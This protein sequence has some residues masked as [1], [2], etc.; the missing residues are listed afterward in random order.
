[1]TARARRSSSIAD[2][3]AASCSARSFLPTLYASTISPIALASAPTS[4]V[5]LPP[6]GAGRLAAVA[7]RKSL[8]VRDASKVSSGM[9]APLRSVV[10]S[11][12]RPAA[13]VVLHAFGR[14]LHRREVRVRPLARLHVHQ[15]GLRRADRD[16][17]LAHRR[18]RK[19][20]HLI[21]RDRINL[22]GKSL[23]RV[24]AKPEQFIQR[25]IARL[26]LR[27]LVIHRILRRDQSLRAVKP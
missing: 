22:I 25:S 12:Y 8:I 6:P 21:E 16:Q 24:V 3:S 23:L 2:F 11:L 18:A 9:V 10:G 4:A 13:G 26:G 1:M 17:A 15:L 14:Q 7:S 20:P 19:I 5:T 27:R